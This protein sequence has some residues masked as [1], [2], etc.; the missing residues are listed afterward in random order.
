MSV[1]RPLVVANWKLNGDLVLIGEMSAAL[2]ELSDLTAEVVICPPYPYLSSL[3]E[4][5]LTFS[6]GSQNMSEHSYGAFTGEVSAQM[7]Q[8]FD[9]K[10]VII[11]H[12]ERRAIYNE[13]DELIARKFG[14]AVQNGLKPILCVGETEKQRNEGLTHS[15][16]AQ[17]VQAVVDTVGIEAFEDAVVAYEPVWAIGTGKTATAEMAQDV[18]QFIRQKLAEYDADIANKLSI[19]YGGSV[20]SK[21]SEELFAQADIDGGLVGGASLKV[22]EFLAICQSA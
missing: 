18:H 6:L 1:R 21:N 3:S 4:R 16:I 15:V 17:Q 8:V 22:E 12:S 19:L 2:N 5:K 7:L 10:Y 13:T 14:Q 9:V 20:N 11:G